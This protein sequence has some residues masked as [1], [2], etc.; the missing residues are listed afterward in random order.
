MAA[1]PRTD[2]PRKGGAIPV[3]VVVVGD[4]G[5]GKTSLTSTYAGIS[6]IESNS[7]SAMPWEVQQK[8]TGLTGHLCVVCLWDVSAE[9]EMDRLRPLAYHQ[10][11]LFL[12]CFSVVQPESYESARAKWAREVR[13]HASSK[14]VQLVVVGLMADLRQDPAIKARLDDKNLAPIQPE[15]G[16][17]LAQQ[18][19][20]RCYVEC[21]SLS[22][23]GVTDAVEKAVGSVIPNIKKGIM[24][25]I[26]K[27]EDEDRRQEETAARPP[28]GLTAINTED[29]DSDDDDRGHRSSRLPN[30]SEEGGPARHV[31]NPGGPPS[32]VDE[33]ESFAREGGTGGNL[34]P[35]IHGKSGN[36]PEEKLQVEGG[37]RDN[38]EV[39]AAMEGTPAPAPVKTGC[40]CAVM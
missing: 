2:W 3:K 26:K 19:N 27:K 8:T 30:D 29:N 34:S 25:G 20:A 10:A 21:S 12:L 18:L 6:D 38:L 37:E 31:E 17:S 35:K 32:S 11:D 1:K 36:Y 24:E 9:E 16:K 39:G 4:G 15:Q 28:T 23:Q 14:E 7:S 33:G 5:C 40:N 22:K 13:F